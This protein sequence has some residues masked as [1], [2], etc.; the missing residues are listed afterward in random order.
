MYLVLL[1]DFIAL[2]LAK[3]HEERPSTIKMRRF[4]ETIDLKSAS[5]WDKFS[6]TRFGV[7]FNKNE[8]MPLNTLIRDSK[9][10]D[11]KTENTRDFAKRENTFRLLLTVG[12]ERIVKA[13]MDITEDE[14]R[15]AWDDDDVATKIDENPLEPVMSSLLDMFNVE[16]LE[17]QRRENEKVKR[18]I[19]QQSQ[20]LFPSSFQTPDHKRKISD[21][22][23]GTRSTETTPTKLDQP[24][25]KV[26]SLQN[27]FVAAIIKDV[28]WTRRIDVSWGE[29]RRMFL[30]Y[31]EYRV[32]FVFMLTIEPT[33]RRFNTLNDFPVMGFSLGG[34]KPL[35]MVPCA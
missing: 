17:S 30:T 34:S 19:T 7:E 21:S 11:P 22:S 28:W 20:S 1:T 33:K 10:Y 29:E 27:N 2:K 8:H 14:L 5:A 18:I 3:K 16:S 15:R 26:Q 13:S 12:Y 23:F 24:E 9:F 4:G 32:F 31:S 6:L 35:L 25:A